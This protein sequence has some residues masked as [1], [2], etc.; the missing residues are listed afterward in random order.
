MWHLGMGW[1]DWRQHDSGLVD[2]RC[3]DFLGGLGWLTTRG[4]KTGESKFRN[5]KHLKQRRGQIMISQGSDMRI[6]PIE[7]EIPWGFV[8]LVV[9]EVCRSL[10]TDYLRWMEDG[11][12]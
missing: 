5:R 11:F 2:K 4:L 12:H 1:G 7:A 3:K 6:S 10:E 9:E 8:I